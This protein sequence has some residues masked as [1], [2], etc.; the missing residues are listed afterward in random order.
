MLNLIEGGAPWPSDLLRGKVAFLS[1]DLEITEDPLAYRVLLVL[2]AV[3]RVQPSMVARSDSWVVPQSQKPW[4][5]AKSE[6]FR[7]AI[8]P[9]FANAPPGV[10]AHNPETWDPSIGPCVTG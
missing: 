4:S 5:A 9:L 1:K 10:P 7:A 8:L 2:P 6:A 3:Q